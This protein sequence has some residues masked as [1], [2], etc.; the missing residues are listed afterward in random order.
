MVGEV[1]R[2]AKQ[3]GA[4]VKVGVELGDKVSPINTFSPSEVY[5]DVNGETSLDDTSV[6]SI[7]GFSVSIRY[8]RSQT[9][10]IRIRVFSLRLFDSMEWLLPDAR[11]VLRSYYPN[12]HLDKMSPWKLGHSKLESFFL[13]Q[14]FRMQSYKIEILCAHTSNH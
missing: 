12:N 5:L 11:S 7:S 9:V 14:T 4:L 6:L 1:R 8:Y 10:E 2:I 3:G 13:I